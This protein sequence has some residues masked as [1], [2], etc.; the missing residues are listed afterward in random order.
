MVLDMKLLNQSQERRSDTMPSFAFM[1]ILESTPERYDR[2]IRL[3]SRG[4]I[5]EVYKMIADSVSGDGRT[6]LDIGCGTGNVSLACAMKGSRVMG[7]DVDAGML[8]VARKK[9]GRAK[10]GD[11]IEFVELGV[12]EIKSKVKEKSIDACVS[13]LAFSE[14]SDEEQSY[15]ILAAYSILKPGGTMIIADE[16][17]PRGIGRRLLHALTQTPVKILTYVLAQSST[18]PVADLSAKFQQAGFV[19]IEITR[20]WGDSF[21][22]MKGCRGA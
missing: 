9:A 7:I 10:L 6:I 19:D 13:C 5:D 21:M 14:L 3:L 17:K 12:A 4:R 22:V 2:G 15:A 11:R 1:K 16:V 18:H 20:T 8:E